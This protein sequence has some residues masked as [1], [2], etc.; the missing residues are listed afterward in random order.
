VLDPEHDAP[1]GHGHVAVPVRQG[2][3][4]PLLLHHR[5]TLH[6]H[7]LETTTEGEYNGDVG[8]A[9]DV[10]YVQSTGD[11]EDEYINAYDA[12]KDDAYD[13]DG[14]DDCDVKEEYEGI[15]EENEYYDIDIGVLLVVQV[16]PF[17]FTRLSIFKSH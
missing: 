8:G 4:D 16:L 11:V 9:G 14:D 12:Y 3:G 5:R 13:D 15:D 10:H 17:L 7:R 1:P 2:L 6:P